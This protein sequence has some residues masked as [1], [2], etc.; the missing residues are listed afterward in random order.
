MLMNGTVAQKEITGLEDVAWYIG[1]HSYTCYQ[2]MYNLHIATLADGLR[3]VN[4]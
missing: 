4:F 3:Y 2:N 1:S